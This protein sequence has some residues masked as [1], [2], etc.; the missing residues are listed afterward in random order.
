MHNCGSMCELQRALGAVLQHKS[1]GLLDHDAQLWLCELQRALGAVLRNVVLHASRGT[2]LAA[3]SLAVR[4]S[5]P[6]L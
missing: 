2:C 5:S 4:N 1:P 6:T 3:A